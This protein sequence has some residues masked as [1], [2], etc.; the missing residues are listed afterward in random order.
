MYEYLFRNFRSGKGLPTIT[1][2]VWD[3]RPFKGI[4][5]SSTPTLRGARSGP[6][7]T[8][9]IRRHSTARR[10]RRL[11]SWADMLPSGV[12]PATPPTF[13]RAC[14]HASLRSQRNCGRP[15]T[16][17]RALPTE[18]SRVGGLTW[19]SACTHTDAAFSVVTLQRRQWAPWVTRPSRTTARS[20]PDHT[21]IAQKI[22][23]LRTHPHTHSL[24]RHRACG[25][26]DSLTFHEYLQEILRKYHNTCA[27]YQYMCTSSYA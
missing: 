19:A 7:T 24:D 4:S 6:T 3:C 1:R 27:C 12:R 26:R 23:D 8:S 15:K 21:R 25:D 10:R 14:G 22:T 20:G 2:Y 17:L 18:P 16:S 5:T 9:V 13:S 11:L